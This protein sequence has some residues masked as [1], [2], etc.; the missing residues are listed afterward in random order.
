MPPASRTCT[1]D[2]RCPVWLSAF[3]DANHRRRRLKKRAF[4][5]LLSLRT[6][7]EVGTY[8]TIESLPYIHEWQHSLS[9]YY[10]HLCHRSPSPKR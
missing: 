3:A 9:R 5:G 8:I 10:M 2:I 1:G 4:S 6:C 7:L